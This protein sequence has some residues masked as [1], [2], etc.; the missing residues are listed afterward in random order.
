MVWS[1]LRTYS[2]VLRS[3]VISVSTMTG[4]PS[5]SKTGLDSSSV[6]W[7][8]KTKLPLVRPSSSIWFMTSCVASLNSMD[9]VS[10]PEYLLTTKV[11]SEATSLPE[12]S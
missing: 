5:S 12:A 4:L 10:W 3:T 6:C 2:L 9:R 8:G 1:Q 7:M 11:V